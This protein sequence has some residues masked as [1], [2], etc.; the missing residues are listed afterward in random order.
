[1]IVQGLTNIIRV[2]IRIGLL[3]PVRF[4]SKNS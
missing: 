1:M 4:D 3:I 2:K